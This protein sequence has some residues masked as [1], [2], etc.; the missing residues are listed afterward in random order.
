MEKGEIIN[1]DQEASFPRHINKKLKYHCLL[2]LSTQTIKMA[3][4]QH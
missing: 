2:V 3:N 4:S 1:D